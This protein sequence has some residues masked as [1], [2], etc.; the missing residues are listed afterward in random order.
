[1][2][3]VQTNQWVMLRRQ[4]SDMI[5][6]CGSLCCW[7][8]FVNARLAEPLTTADGSMGG[9]PFRVGSVIDEIPAVAEN[10]PGRVK[11]A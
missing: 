8:F 10:Q 2:N 9:L 11:T 6:S 3:R 1:M 4:A 7:K 5:E